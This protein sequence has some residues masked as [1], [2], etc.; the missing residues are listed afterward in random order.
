MSTG[1]LDTEVITVS[2]NQP[3]LNDH[4]DDFVACNSSLA[5]PRLRNVLSEDIDATASVV[6]EPSPERESSY[7]GYSAAVFLTVN[8]A[9]GAGLLNFPYAFNEAGG[10]HISLIL[11]SVLL[12][13]IVGA[14]FI[15]THCTNESN[16]ESFQDVVDFYCGR[17]IKNI[18]SLAIILYSYGACLTFIIIIG[19]QFDR[20]F[21]SLHGSNFCHLWYMNRNFTMSITSIILILPLCFSGKIAFL[22]YSSSVG[23]FVIGYLIIL[24]VH[25]WVYLDHS[26][27]FV[28]TRPDHWTDIFAVLPALSFGYQCHL[29]WVPTYACMKAEKA[30]SPKLGATIV[31]SIFLCCLAYTSVSVMG[32][33]TFGANIEADLMENYDARRPV[34][35]VGI[36][37][38]AFKTVTSYPLL[39]F[40]A[41]VALEDYCARFFGLPA[42]RV[43]E[44]KRRSWIVLSWFFSTLV[45]AIL[46]PDIAVAIDLLGSL[47][48]TFIFVIPGA[49]LIKTTVTKDPDIILI[50]DKLWCLVGSLY[51]MIGTFLFGLILSQAIVKDLI[52]RQSK[53]AIPLC[54]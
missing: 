19:D 2:D 4:F 31:I 48:V 8:A 46:V 11:Q 30:S 32:L 14:L 21:A 39:L 9:L 24:A 29:S 51:I 45:F 37:A 54:L 27:V 20:V 49:C 28:K 15:L 44:L 41:R 5:E 25:E 17:R 1:Q 22:T 7:I 10:L 53:N 47:A 43:T 35:L 6:L 12:L 3:L 18:V 26:N 34:V 23:V 50:K 16:A 42:S 36:G 52:E 38:I 13:L 33:L 40:C